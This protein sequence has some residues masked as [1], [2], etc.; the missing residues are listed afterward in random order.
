[1]ERNTF[2]SKSN[3]PAEYNTTIMSLNEI[4]KMAFPVLRVI[5]E[6]ASTWSILHVSFKMIL[7]FYY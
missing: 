5:W 1:M 2:Q 6:L 7:F 3:A 4:R